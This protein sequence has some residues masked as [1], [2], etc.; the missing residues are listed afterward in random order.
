MNGTRPVPGI[1]YGWYVVAAIM[2]VLSVGSGLGFYNLSVY[3]KAFVAHAGFTVSEASTATACFFV[4]SGLAGLGIGALI[5]RY[6][7]RWVITG[8][9]LTCGGTMFAAAHV[10]E[11]WQLYGFYAVFGVGYS[12]C[13]LLPCTTL[14][15]RWFAR[16]RSQAL[17]IA[18]TGLSLG[19]ILLTPLSA[20]LIGQLGLAGATPW[21]AL[22]FVF[23][24]I[25]ITWIMIRPSPLAY[26][27]GPDGDPIALDASGVPIPADGIDFE[28]AIRSRFFVL[29]TFTFI[30]AMMAQ[31]GTIAHLFSLVAGRTGSD[32][33]AALALAVMAGASVV[34]RLIGGWALAYMSSR[35]F[36]I[37]LITGQGIVLTLFAF[38]DTTT[39]LVATSLLFGFTVGNLLM[40]APLMSAEAFGLKA[41]GRI[42]SINQLCTMVGVASGPVVMGL[43]YAHGGGYHAAFLAMAAASAIAFL[44]ICA[45]GPV[46]ALLDG[47][48]NA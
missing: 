7:V 19:G 12:A 5:E 42:F 44:L 28:A 47:R 22:I 14:V 3:L 29:M 21:L 10:H 40:M 48:L 25:P 1:F 15:A 17:S 23:G 6:D 4:A 11:I 8:G 9:A 30:F 39:G 38:A 18:S 35:G 46:R 20:K 34:G 37:G 36:V 16:R 24:I 31:V 41:Y 43:L 26:G 13:A 32:D 2:V 33:A 27:T 45:A